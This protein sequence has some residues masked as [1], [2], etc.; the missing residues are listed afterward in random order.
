MG[1]GNPTPSEPLSKRG[2]RRLM[3]IASAWRY[4]RL[5]R[6]EEATMS[7]RYDPLLSILGVSMLVG[8]VACSQP[9]APTPPGFATSVAGPP[10]T[11]P[12][13]AT[14]TVSGT[15]WVHGVNGT[16]TPATGRV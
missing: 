15:V 5:T 8:G 1:R 4:T 7:R 16:K 14:A 12:S 10:N 11:P 3:Q 2:W 6:S 13:A 9:T